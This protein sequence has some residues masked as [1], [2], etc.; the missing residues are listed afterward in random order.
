[1]KKSLA[2][3]L[4]LLLMVSSLTPALAAL[5]VLNQRMATRSGPGTQYTEELGTLPR[6]TGIT[7]L[8]YVHDKN[9]VPWGLVE[10]YKNNQL[11]RA[12]TGMKRIDVVSGS[13]DFRVEQYT[14][15][16][17]TMA[18]TVY[19]G[20]GNQYAARSRQAPAGIA[21]LVVEQEGDFL[22][23]EYTLGDRP[24]RGYLP[25]HAT[26]FAPAVTA[27]PQSPPPAA[28]GGLTVLS[29]SGD[30]TLNLQWAAVPGAREYLLVARDASSLSPIRAQRA[31]DAAATVAD[32]PRGRLYAVEIMALSTGNAGGD[33]VLAST[34]IYHQVP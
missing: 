17:T 26:T 12:Y 15:A 8:Y 13:A 2:F 25:I 10:F 29:Q 7:L 19:Y 34:T 1:M 5:A 32:L 9:Q 33:L 6:D 30:S 21:L 27:A 16:S 24:M 22:L 14:H 3:L 18:A 11:H 28:A 23:C 20:P 4:V 31:Q